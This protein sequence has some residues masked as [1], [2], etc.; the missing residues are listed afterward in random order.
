MKTS[1]RNLLIG[2][3]SALLLVLA[4]V[5]AVLA[6]ET[7]EATS[8]ADGDRFRA[9]IHRLRDRDGGR[10]AR[11][12]APP[13]VFDKEA[14]LQAAAGALGLTADELRAAKADGRRLPALLAEQGVARAD[15]AEAMRAARQ[16]MIDDALQSGAITQA[17]ADRLN[18]RMERGLRRDGRFARAGARPAIFDGEALLQAAAEALG[19]TADELRAAKADGRRLP[20]LLAE[21]GV[22]RAD[23]AEAM[24]AA[25]QRMIDDA[26]QSGAITQAQADRLNTRMERGLRRG[27][28]FARAGARPAIFDGEALLQAAAGALGLTADELRAAKA[29]GRRLPALLA[30]QGVARTD[31]AEAMRAAKQRMINDALQSGAI[32]QA[33]ADRLHAWMERGLRKGF[34]RRGHRA[35]EFGQHAMAPFEREGHDRD[36][37]GDADQGAAG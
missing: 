30:E 22:A 36:A 21:Q 12:G 33:Q 25:R 15:F 20:A 17:Q 1:A 2:L 14:L 6:A 7:P 8:D 10:F 5:G 29:D 3:L 32:T 35:R 31:F 19:L 4:S 34:G 27:G 37:A 26:L 28:R 23:F 13:A 16:R 24:R 9:R 18:A 11:A